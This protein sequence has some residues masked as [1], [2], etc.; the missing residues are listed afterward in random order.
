MAGLLGWSEAE[1]EAQ[2]ARARAR[3]A[4]DLDFAEREA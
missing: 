1:R 4:G 3:L 2:L